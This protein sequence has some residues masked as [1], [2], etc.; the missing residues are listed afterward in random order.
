MSLLCSKYHIFHINDIKPWKSEKS[1]VTHSL[2]AASYFS[3]TV[4]VS[5]DIIYETNNGICG[6]RRDD[7]KYYI[8]P[9]LHPLSSYF[10]KYIYSP[11]QY[12]ILTEREESCLL[13]KMTYIF[14]V[15]YATILMLN[16][17]KKVHQLWHYRRRII[18]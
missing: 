11:L 6:W 1:S 10:H 18:G 4:I 8:K 5:Y 13:W 15:L 17:H 16:H 14:D 7:W 9:E 3:I 12:E 2:S